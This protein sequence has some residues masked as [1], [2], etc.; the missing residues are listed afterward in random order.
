MIEDAAALEYKLITMRGKDRVPEETL[1]SLACDYETRVQAIMEANGITDPDWVLAYSAVVIPPNGGTAYSS[2]SSS[3]AVTGPSSAFA[4]AASPPLPPP[5]SLPAPPSSAVVSYRVPRLPLAP[6]PTTTTSAAAGGGSGVGGPSYRHQAG[7]ARFEPLS[8]QPQPE[9]FEPEEEDL[10]RFEANPNPNL[11]LK[12]RAREASASLPSSSAFATSSS[13]AG[14]GASVASGGR[15]ASSAASPSVRVRITHALGSGQERGEAAT[16]SAMRHNELAADELAGDELAVNELQQN[17]AG[18]AEHGREEASLLQEHSR[19]STPPAM[20]MVAHIGPAS[21]EAELSGIARRKRALHEHVG[22]VHCPP[23]R[24]ARPPWLSPHAKLG[25]AAVAGSILV[26]AAV[27][28]AKRLAERL[29][30]QR[31]RREAQ[32]WEEFQRQAANK[33]RLASCLSLDRAA[34]DSGCASRGSGGGGNG[35]PAEGGRNDKEKTSVDEAQVAL[36]R[37]YEEI[38]HGYESGIAQSYEL[39]LRDSGAQKAGRFRGGMPPKFKDK[40]KRK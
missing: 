28:G 12:R 26:V 13:G 32:L 16:G 22:G 31:Q 14:S 20:D 38:V 11:N 37:D 17:D 19:S 36:R 4:P 1:W 27:A 34:R 2:S 35:E 8:S 33:S 25:L 10:H 39:F 23:P 29:A 9:P 30:E 6:P 24:E 5:P 40:S 18:A 21:K 7:R 3:A 15:A